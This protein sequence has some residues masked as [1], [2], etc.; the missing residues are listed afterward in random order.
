M[1]SADTL[2][3]INQLRVTYSVVNNKHLFKKSALHAVNGVSLRINKGEIVGLVGESGSGKSTLGR[4]ILRLENIAAGEVLYKGNDITHRSRRDLQFFRKE[5]AMIFQNP[6][7]SLNPRQ[8]IGELIKEVLT[9]HHICSANELESRVDELLTLAGLST[10]YKGRYPKQ[11]SG[12]QCQRVAIARAL[13]INPEFIVADECVSALDVSVQAQII[14]LLLELNEKINLTIL[15]IAH[16]LAIVR[17][18]CDRTAVMYLG[19][20]VEEGPTQRLFTAPKHPYTQAL[21]QAIPDIRPDHHLPQQA[22][23]GEPPSPLDLPQGCAFYPRCS[24]ARAECQFTKPA[25]I[26]QQHH[27]YTCILQ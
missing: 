18:L 4:A 10:D 25:E 8:T 21:I 27:R 9:V 23:S 17:K 16:D 13:A 2:M 12:G 5:A 26:T 24:Q 20:I 15:F 1:S 14:N 3:E 22:L 7:G 19:E 11:L 6:L